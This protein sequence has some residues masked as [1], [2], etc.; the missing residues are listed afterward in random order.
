MVKH[1]VCFR[2]KEPTAEGCRQ[3]QE[4][5]LSMREHVP[6]LRALQVGINVTQSARAYDLVLE[7]ELDDLDALAAYDA[8]A[9]HCGVVKAYMHERTADCICVDYLL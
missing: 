5:L 4:K 3:A 7:A 2:L 9:Y 1:I 8:D 6:M